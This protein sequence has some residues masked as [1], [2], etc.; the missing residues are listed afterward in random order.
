MGFAV[1]CRLV[2]VKSIRFGWV[3][4]KVIGSLVLGER[5]S[6]GGGERLGFE[7]SSDKGFLRYVLFIVIRDT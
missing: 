2:Y 7:S 5:V 6:L 1:K 4:F 3:K